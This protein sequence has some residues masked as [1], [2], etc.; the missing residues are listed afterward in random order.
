[1]NYDE[2]EK[3]LLSPIAYSHST[4]ERIAKHFMTK[5]SIVPYESDIM[6][7]FNHE[8]EFQNQNHIISLHQRCSGRVPM[9]IFHYI[10]LTYVYSGNLIITVENQ[11]I[12]LNQG[13]IIIF[14]KHVPHSVAPTEENDLGINIILHENFFSHRFI[15]NLPKD[16]LITQFMIELMNH[17]HTHNHYLLFHTHKDHLI[18]NCVQNILCEHFDPIES[19]DELI[20]NFIMILITHLARKSDYNTNL[21]LEAYK[22][23]ALLDNILKYIREKNV[24]VDKITNIPAYFIDFALITTNST[25]HITSF[26]SKTTF[27]AVDR[28][29]LNNYDYVIEQGEINGISW[30]KWKSGKLIQRGFIITS[31]PATITFPKPYA[32]TNY[33]AFMT[34]R[35]SD[36]TQNPICAIQSGEFK[37]TSMVVLAG[38]LTASLNWITIGQGA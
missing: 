20:D 14:D 9:H 33:V 28:N 3:K 26:N 35:R 38:N 4:S 22:N 24:N 19:S 6:F 16:Q 17:Q 37:T 36:N 21:S 34:P 2:L 13:D 8:R 29:E 25:G 15:N 1:M 18:H 5:Y 11:T 7:I 32:N 23:K 12:S 31:A 30:E 27:H 10:V